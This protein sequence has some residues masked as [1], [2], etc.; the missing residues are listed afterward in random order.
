M[1]VKRRD[2][3]LAGDRF[4]EA[5]QRAEDQMAHYLTRAWGEADDVYVFNDLRLI[6][7]TGSDRDAAQFDHL[8]LHR[9]GAVIIESKS[10]TGRVRV[11]DRNEWT[12]TWQGGGACGMPSP[13]LQAERQ[14]AFLRARLV[15]N[16]AH[17]LEKRLGLFSCRFDSW[18]VDTLVAISDQGI[19]D[20][21]RG[22]DLS[23]VCKADQAVDKARTLLERQRREV[24]A[25]PVPLKSGGLMLSHEDLD[26]V[27]RFLTLQHT[28]HHPAAP[29]KPVQVVREAPELLVLLQSPRPAPTPL[30]PSA[31]VLK[32]TSVFCGKCQSEK[33][34]IQYGKY[35]Y[36]LRCVSCNE[37]SALNLI[38]LRCGA[39]ER[40]RKSGAQFFAECDGNAAECKGGSRLFHV[41]APDA[42]SQTTRKRAAA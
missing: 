9:A 3:R 12:R 39:K 11:N 17:L 28:P 30:Q 42:A 36:Y 21:A 10:V 22:V 25:L 8:I 33:V 5:G 37:N 1:I 16:S 14:K 24:S 2:A 34:N 23:A 4:T 29:V 19:I 27:S 35:G 20:S 32:T 41:N 13:I 6:H 15:E 40:V 7:T 38:C 18:A 31:P 26:R